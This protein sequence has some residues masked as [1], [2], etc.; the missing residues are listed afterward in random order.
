M[1]HQGTIDDYF[2][3]VGIKK[4]GSTDPKT[5]GVK[6]SPGGASAPGASRGPAPLRKGAGMAQGPLSYLE[7][8]LE[9][10]GRLTV[11]PQSDGQFR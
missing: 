4:T 6:P 10:R 3:V 7:E 2:K 11:C 9:T 5:S 1:R 8:S